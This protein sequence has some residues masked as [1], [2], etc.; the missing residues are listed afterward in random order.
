M[1]TSRIAELA[2]TIATHT[3]KVDAHLATNGLPDLSFDP[4]SSARHVYDTEIATSR[5]S[6]LAATDELHALIQGPVDII[7]AKPVSTTCRL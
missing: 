2:A 4:D 6:L 7:T 3:Q 5:Q 1:S